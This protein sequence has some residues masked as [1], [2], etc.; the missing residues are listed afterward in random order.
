MDD[1]LFLFASFACTTNQIIFQ[2]QGVPLA[3]H[4]HQRIW[5]DH[6]LLDLCG[7]APLRIKPSCNNVP[8]LFTLLFCGKNGID[9]IGM[10]RR[11][12]RAGDSLNQDGVIG[13]EVAEEGRHQLNGFQ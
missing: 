1:N 3:F 11:E 12:R 7:S 13:N 10:L 2:N 4:L 6:A 9:G 8:Y 5:D